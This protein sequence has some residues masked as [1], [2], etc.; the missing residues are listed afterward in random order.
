M[1]SLDSPILL[2]DDDVVMQQTTQKALHTAGY[3]NIDLADNGKQA[4]EKIKTVL[5]AKKMY[6]II[7]LDWNMPEMDG[8]AFLKICRGELALKDVAIIMVT[9][10]TDQKSLILALGSGATTF[11]KKPVSA[12]S[13][14]RKLEQIATW[15]DA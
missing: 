11:M 14:L 10:F 2:V 8:L 13:I 6:K 4:L 7:F 5:E 12:E 1:L 9:S 15:I 3:T